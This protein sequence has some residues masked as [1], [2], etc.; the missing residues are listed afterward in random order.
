MCVLIW[1]DSSI[2]SSEAVFG[3]PLVLSG[4]FLDT[5]ELLS[6][7]YLRRIRQIIKNNPV[8]PPHHSST[9]TNPV[10]EQIP[11]SLLCSSHVFVREDSSKHPLSPLYR[12]PYLVVSR[13]PKYFSLQMGSKTD[14][15]SVDRL[16]TVLSEFPVTAQTPPCRGRPL[17]SPKPPAPFPPVPKPLTLKP[18]APPP[19]ISGHPT[20]FP[21]ATSPKK[22]VH[23]SPPVPAA[24][25]VR[26]FPPI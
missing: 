19:P 17:L 12:G 14:S 2:S 13:S 10:Q 15:V 18:P 9:Q 4:E 6:S 25:S 11:P 23:F 20:P 21:R 24:P 3:S 22:K 1:F 7:E 26:L 8:F 16:K 5:T